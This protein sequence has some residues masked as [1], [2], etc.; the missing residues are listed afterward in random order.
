MKEFD[1]FRIEFDSQDIEKIV[2]DHARKLLKE[3]GY[4][5]DHSFKEPGDFYPDVSFRGVRGIK[6]G[7]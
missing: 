4:E 7:T 5:L 2:E 1:Q 3:K 6:T